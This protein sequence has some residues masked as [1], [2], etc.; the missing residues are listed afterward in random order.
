MA[1]VFEADRFPAKEHEGIE[2]FMGHKEY[3][4]TDNR[5]CFNSGPREPIQS[6]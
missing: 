1:F 6:N 5:V 4:F 2:P 3:C